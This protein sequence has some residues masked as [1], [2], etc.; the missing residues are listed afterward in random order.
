[1]ATEGM[2]DIP[3][4]AIQPPKEEIVQPS[5]PIKEPIAELAEAPTKQVSKKV[6]STDHEADDEEDDEVLD[7]PTVPTSPVRRK[8]A[9]AASKEKRKG[10]HLFCLVCN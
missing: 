1:M 4:P 7:L 3:L 2:P 10:M 9:T 6:S 5:E 8:Q